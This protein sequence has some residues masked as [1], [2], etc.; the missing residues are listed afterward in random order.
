MKIC[1]FGA[2]AIGGHLAF[3]LAQA[4]AEVSVV[5]RGDNLTAIRRDGLILRTEAGERS[6]R[7]AA[8]DD[9]RE[10]GP[11]EL[12]LVTVKAPALP[13]IAQSMVP[14]LD[15]ETPVLFVT[16]GIPW[17]YYYQHGGPLDGTRLP[18]VDPG[19]AVWNAVGPQ[20]AIGGIAMSACTV[21]APGVVE[22]KGGERPMVLGEPNGVLTPRVERIAAL[23]RQAGF[24]T[25]VT[26][27]IRDR[28]WAKLLMNLGSGPM[29]VLAP[30]PLQQLFAEAPCL[31]ARYRI[32]AEGQAIAEAMGCRVDVDVDATTRQAQG[33]AHIPSIAQDVLRGRMLELDAMFRV[34]LEMGRAKGVSTPTLDLLVTLAMLKARAAGIYDG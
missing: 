2:G 14:L 33:S 26:E 3:Q 8:S 9:A 1:V 7:V 19:D 24:P 15:A 31:D 17:W 22:V 16:N 23:L 18:R 32:F 34:P 27:R 30:V 20:R 21:V 13:Q 6:C 11:Q 28:I 25:E 12:V 4:G 29:A 10:L 5:V